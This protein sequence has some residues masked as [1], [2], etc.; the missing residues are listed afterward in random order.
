MSK[1]LVTFTTESCFRAC[2]RG[3]DTLFPMPIANLILICKAM[4]I[5]LIFVNIEVHSI[6]NIKQIPIALQN[7]TGLTIGIRIGCPIV[8]VISVIKADVL[9]FIC[10]CRMKIYIAVILIVLYGMMVARGEESS[11]HAHNHVAEC[12]I[13]YCKIH[14]YPESGNFR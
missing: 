4:G 1:I 14:T 2:Y 12:K 11:I 5:C 3:W 6:H 10:L 7:K 13:L 9:Q 8:C